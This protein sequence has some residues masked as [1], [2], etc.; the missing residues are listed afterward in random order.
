MMRQ[1]FHKV[2][3]FSDWELSHCKLLKL[4]ETKVHQAGRKCLSFYLLIKINF[5]QIDGPCKPKNR[6]LSINRAEPDF[7]P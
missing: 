2:L 7:T 6:T 5:S 4:P 3:L 1:Y